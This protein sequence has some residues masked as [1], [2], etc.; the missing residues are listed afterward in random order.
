MKM[1]NYYEKKCIYKISFSRAKIKL[2]PKIGGK[3]PYL[4]KLFGAE[5][6]L[7]ENFVMKMAYGDKKLFHNICSLSIINFY[8]I[9][10]CL[11]PRIGGFVNLFL[12]IG[13]KHFHFAIDRYPSV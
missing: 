1:F 7:I 6:V 2:W 11:K 12:F 5:I 4:A 3:W 8:F 13:I 9:I 10:Y